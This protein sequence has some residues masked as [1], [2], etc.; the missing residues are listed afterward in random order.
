MKL[1]KLT[2]KFIWKLLGSGPTH[3]ELGSHH[4]CAYNEKK[5]NKIKIN[6]LSWNHQRTE[7]TEQADNP[8][9]GKTR[10]SRETQLRSV[11]LEQKFLSPLTGRSI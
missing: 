6:D 9:S 2:Q 4:T 1:G 10:T 3:T 11:D 5:L 7:V 8:K